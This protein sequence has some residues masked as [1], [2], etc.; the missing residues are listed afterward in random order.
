[1]NESLFADLIPGAWNKRVYQ[2][3]EVALPFQIF[4]PAPEEGKNERPAVLLF[5][6][7]DGPRG[8]DNEMQLST[9]ECTLAKRV[10]AERG[11][12]IVLAPHCPV[13]SHW[14]FAKNEDGYRIPERESPY[15]HAAYSL[16]LKVLDKPGADPARVYLNGYSCGAFALWWLLARYPDT[17]AAA[18]SFAGS[19]DPAEAGLYAKK[20][21]VWI[22][23]GD[24]DT[25]VPFSAFETLRDAVLAAG[26]E[27]RLTVCHGAGHGIASF[28]AA[29]KDL[30]NWLFKQKKG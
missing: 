26:G 24:R 27:P 20:V 13:T 11:N 2:G 7:G 25:V 19:G 15:L 29:E 12:C 28:I 9:G 6:H 30:V 17:F 8:D 10:I 3:E 22:F 5:L 18:V 21:P 14:I 16:L 1:M 23:H 4:L